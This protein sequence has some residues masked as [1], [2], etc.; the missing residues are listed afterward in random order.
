MARFD[1]GLRSVVGD[2]GQRVDYSSEKARTRLGW[3]P[4][5]IEETIVDC[6]RSLIEHDVAAAGAA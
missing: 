6:A 4:R 2:L 5:P 3:S 1:P